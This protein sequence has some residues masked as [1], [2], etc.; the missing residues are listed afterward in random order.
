MS[1][2]S[3]DQKL[4]GVL[5][6]LEARRCVPCKA[7]IK[8]AMDLHERVPRLNPR[9]MALANARVKLSADRSRIVRLKLT[10]L[11]EVQE[12]RDV[13]KRLADY[14]NVRYTN[15]LTQFKNKPARDAIIAEALSP[16]SRRITPIENVLVL[17]DVI[18]SDYDATSFAIRD[19]CTALTLADREA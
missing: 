16:L 9:G 7:Y 3:T 6:N 18:L 4:V 13:N 2:I 11:R 14:L 19:S 8:E 15:F 17:L 5:K 10:C 12:L 1:L